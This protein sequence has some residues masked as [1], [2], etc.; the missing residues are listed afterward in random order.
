MKPKLI[1]Q[2]V[3]FAILICGGIIFI[4]QA[5]LTTPGEPSAIAVDVAANLRYDEL[6]EQVVP[7]TGVTI[8]FHWR[9][10][11]QKLVEAGAI[12]LETFEAISGGLTDEQRRIL[13]NDDVDSI[14]LG[15]DNIR[16]W[17]NV[18]WA[19]GLTQQSKVLA[20]GPMAKQADIPLG[21]YASTG[22]WTLGALPA[23]DL[24][25]SAQIVTLTTQQDE[26][27]Y[28][29]AQHIFRPCCGNH[30]GFPDCN[31]GMAVLG[32]MALM[33]SQ[34]ASEDDLYQAAL[35][36]NSYAFTNTYITIAAYFALQ[37]VGWKDVDVRQILGPEYSSIRG[38]QRVA[39][40]VGL[41]PGAPGQSGGC[42]T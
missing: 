10:T 30:T 16:F 38:S 40:A 29:V 18:L 41:I 6:V 17:T 33:A 15:H 7:A 5:Q 11:G 2:T 27:V 9:D 32:L 21:N 31:H 36:F 19:L 26:L 42:S 28:E 35:T 3:T 22:G 13:Q 39:A 23:V 14:T 37:E 1:L 20:D 4:T 8:P 12:D 34:G 24:Y 25:N